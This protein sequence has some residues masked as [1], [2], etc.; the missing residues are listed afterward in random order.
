M[1]EHEPDHAE[2]QHGQP[3]RDRKQREHRWPRLGLSRLRRGFDDPVLLSGCHGAL[4]SWDGARLA[5]PRGAHDG[6]AGSATLFR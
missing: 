2:D 6:N 5:G 4:D 3:G 1:E